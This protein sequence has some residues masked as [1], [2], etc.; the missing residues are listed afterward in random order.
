M[1]IASSVSVI[2]PIWFTLTSS[3]LATFLDPALQD[4]RVGDEHV[5]ADELHLLAELLRQQLPPVQS[6]SATPSSIEMIG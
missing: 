2:V 4:R 6:L 5:V 3:A 1:A